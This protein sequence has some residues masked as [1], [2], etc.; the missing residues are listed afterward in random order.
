MILILCGER[1]IN[2][3]I[4]LIKITF[5]ERLRDLRRGD[6]KNLKKDLEKF[7]NEVMIEIGK[8]NLINM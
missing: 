5:E 8:M 6:N 7:K 3:K 1:I 2:V 4:K